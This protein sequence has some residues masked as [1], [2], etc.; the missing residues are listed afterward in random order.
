MLDIPDPASIDELREELQALPSLPAIS[1][2][3]K[4]PSE[5]K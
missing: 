5:V 4:N 2:V 1:D 3:V